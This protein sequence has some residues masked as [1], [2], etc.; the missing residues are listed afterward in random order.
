MQVLKTSPNLA[1]HFDDCLRGA[2]SSIVGDV[3]LDA[4]RDAGRDP[5]ARLHLLAVRFGSSH[6]RGG[7]GEPR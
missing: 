1:S 5:P 2:L 4:A 3:V 7:R 6:A